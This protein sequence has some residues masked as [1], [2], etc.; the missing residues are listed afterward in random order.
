MLPLLRRIARKSAPTVPLCVVQPLEERTLFAAGSIIDMMIVYTP[1]ALS[2]A[3]SQ[4]ALDYRINRSIADTNMAMA[5]S[6]VNATIRL[7]YE[8]EVNYVESGTTLT[9]LDNIQSGTGAFSGIP[10]LRSQYGADLVSLWVGSDSGDEAGRAF[11]PDNLSNP[12]PSNGYQIIQEQYATNDYVFAHETGHNLGAGHDASDTTPRAI[13]YAYGKTFTI[14]NYTMGD[15]MSDLSVNGSLVERIPYYSNPDVNY[16]GV[17]TGN[18]INSAQPADDALVM[19]QFAPL[20]ANY[21]PTMVP[22]PAPPQA[23]VQAVVINPTAQTLSLQVAYADDSAVS[24]ANLGTGDILVTGANGF[25]QLATFQGVDHATDGPQRIATYQISIANQSQDPSTYSFTLE[26][27]RVED[28]S[29]NFAAGGMLG[30]PAGSSFPD[31]AGPRLVSAYDA[32]TI[33]GTTLQFSSEVNADS[34]T[35]FYHFN[36]AAQGQFTATLSNLSASVNELLVQDGNQDGVIQSGEVLAQPAGSGTNPETIAM[37]LSSGTYYLWVAPPVANTVSTYTL[38]MSDVPIPPPPPPPGPPIPPT[39]PPPPPPLPPPPLPPPPAVPPPPPAPS[40][41]VA[42][43]IINSGGDGASLGGFTVYADLK[44]DGHVDVGDPTA[45][46]DASGAYQLTGLPAGT[47]TI[48]LVADPGWRQTIN[49][50]D[51]SQIAS[52]AANRSV[53]GINFTVTQLGSVLGTVFNDANG[54]GVLN[55]HE[56]SLT[57]WQVYIDLAHTGTFDP[58]SDPMTTTDAWGNFAFTDVAPGTYT[59]RIVPEPG[60]SSTTANDGSYTVTLAP[61]GIIGGLLIGQ[62]AS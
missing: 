15:I 30:N 49:S 4:V 47:F 29:G 42:G 9:D 12:D 28:V 34:P 27:G 31:R 51:G 18:P 25:S 44:N 1:Q 6:Q 50:G 7:V 55:A 45:T 19:N 5:N 46:T 61:G 62:Q 58:S 39:P 56:S 16:Q 48:R 41:V 14:G 35:A 40:G 59:V 53:S 17:P 38:T 3:G 11:Q 54:D 43:S 57:G 21:E 2:Q 24:V 13:S 23:A 33:D 10:A 20:V 32:G 26:A 52:L 8:T 60:W 36:L 37:T 22:D